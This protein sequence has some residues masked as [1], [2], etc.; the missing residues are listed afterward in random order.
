VGVVVFALQGFTREITLPRERWVG[1]IK[2]YDGGTL[3]ECV[4][5]PKLPYTDLAGMFRVSTAGHIIYG[6]FD[7]KYRSAGAGVGV[8]LCA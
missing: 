4:I 2:D 7:L 8:P 6:E 3:M 1:F 5:S